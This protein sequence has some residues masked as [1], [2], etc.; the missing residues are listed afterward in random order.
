MY[1]TVK[2]QKKMLQAEVTKLI[3]DLIPNQ[4]CF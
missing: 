4:K 2:I 1:T 3:S